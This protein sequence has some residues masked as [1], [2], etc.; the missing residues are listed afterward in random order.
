MRRCGIGPWNG[1]YTNRLI[2]KMHGR[3]YRMLDRFD[4]R[5]NDWHHAMAYAIQVTSGEPI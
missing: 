4:Q 3:T 2:W 1:H 5:D